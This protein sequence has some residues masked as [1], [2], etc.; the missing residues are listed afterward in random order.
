MPIY[1]TPK[2]ET[3]A[4][5]LIGRTV[6]SFDFMSFIADGKTYEIS[7]EDAETIE[8][9]VQATVDDKKTYASTRAVKAE[10]KVTVP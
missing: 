8:C 4:E 7:K 3:P 10:E 2:Q 5:K 6:F 1:V 9:I